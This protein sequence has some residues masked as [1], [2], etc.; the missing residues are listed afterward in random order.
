MVERVEAL[1]AVEAAEVQRKA[2][3]QQL[4]LSAED[5]LDKLDRAT[6]KFRMRQ[7]RAEEA[8]KEA[9][10]LANGDEAPPA[11]PATAKAD[12]YARARSAGRL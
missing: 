10:Q 11:H 3:W 4:K 7:T 12:L 9:E 1:E 5:V 6:S 2:E 8:I